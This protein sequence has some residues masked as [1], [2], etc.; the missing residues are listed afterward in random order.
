MSYS[1]FRNSLKCKTHSTCKGKASCGVDTLM[2]IWHYGIFKKTPG[3]F[4]NKT[5]QLIADLV[6]VSNIREKS[7][8]SNLI[9]PTPL[10]NTREEVWDCLCNLVP[11]YKPKG[12]SSVNIIDGF[13]EL[14]KDT[15]NLFNVSFLSEQNCAACDQP[16]NFFLEVGPVL[17][18]D[19]NRNAQFPYEFAKVLESI[20]CDYLRYQLGSKH[21]GLK[22]MHCNHPVDQLSGTLTMPRYLLVEIPVTKSN[23][24]AGLVFEGNVQRPSIMVS[25]SICVNDID[26]NLTS[27][28]QHTPGHYHSIVKDEDLFV[29]MDDMLNSYTQYSTFLGAINRDIG[30]TLNAGI[31]KPAI[32]LGRPCAVNLLVYFSPNRDKGQNF[33]IKTGP[34]SEKNYQSTSPEVEIVILDDTI[35]SENTSIEKQ[36]SSTDQNAKRSKC[37][38]FPLMPTSP[39]KSPS[40]KKVKKTLV[41]SSNK[42]PKPSD[43]QQNSCHN[44]P[45][46]VIL[47]QNFK[48]TSVKRRL[49]EISNDA[50]FLINGNPVSSS[51]LNT[52]YICVGEHQI[53]CTSYEGDL[54]YNAEDVFKILKI[55]EKIKKRGY[56]AIVDSVLIKQKG[57]NINHVFIFC[58][59]NKRKRHFIHK[60][61]LICF[62]VDH[63]CKQYKGPLSVSDKILREKNLSLLSAV[64]C[65]TIDVLGITGEDGLFISK[66]SIDDKQQST[67][68]TQNDCAQTL[69][70]IQ[71]NDNL[72]NELSTNLDYLPNIEE[73]ITEFPKAHTSSLSNSLDNELS[74]VVDTII[75]LEGSNKSNNLSND[76]NGGYSPKANLSLTNFH[77][78]HLSVSMF[79]QRMCYHDELRY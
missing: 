9:C 4:Q 46:V 5:N 1:Y 58:N 72:L 63:V 50:F 64:E 28:V 23:S 7:R 34:Y 35:T 47:D 53:R 40:K 3:L 6:D 49:H 78:F 76:I 20:V 59:T 18:Y 13:M 12:N 21:T 2:E 68:V 42:T 79:P 56:S 32:T 43:L 45:N 26:Y 77:F 57:M 16:L 41:A 19:Q 55:W 29:E 27:A 38:S 37:T 39:F 71:S 67:C 14:G 33:V 24:K 10:C 51:Q 11:S 66:A 52:K 65:T 60:H 25:E 70:E 36:I 69:N 74:W 15:G 17:I 62:L 48:P 75:D 31:L 73:I 44:G 61:A 30:N 54:F 22:C 8:E